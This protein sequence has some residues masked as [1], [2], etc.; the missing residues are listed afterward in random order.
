MA[1]PN[2][3]IPTAS[4]EMREVVLAGLLSC[5]DRRFRVRIYFGE[6]A[7]ADKVVFHHLVSAGDKNILCAKRLGHRPMD[8]AVKLAE[9]NV[10]PG[11]IGVRIRFVEKCWVETN[12]IRIVAIV[13]E[14]DWKLVPV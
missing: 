5:I 3:K 4:Q 9:R 11:P 8:V 1:K 14:Q 12:N 7:V 6:V 2:T 10:R 13:I